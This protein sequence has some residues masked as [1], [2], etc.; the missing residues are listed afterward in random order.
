MYGKKELNNARVKNSASSLLFFSWALFSLF[1]VL[2]FVFSVLWAIRTPHLYFHLFRST[3]MWWKKPEILPS[4]TEFLDHYFSSTCAIVKER[5]WFN[6]YHIGKILVGLLSHNNEIIY[7]FFMFIKLLTDSFQ[8]LLK[9]TQFPMLPQ[10][11]F[12]FYQFF[13]RND[14]SFSG[15]R[16]RGQEGGEAWGRQQV[17]SVGSSSPRSVQKREAAASSKQLCKRQHMVFVCCPVI[18]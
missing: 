9:S 18:Y 14:Y 13:S 7:L 6:S 2:F 5:I 17:K 15:E 12:C 11:L 10:R 8:M 3:I 16:S 4:I 1:A